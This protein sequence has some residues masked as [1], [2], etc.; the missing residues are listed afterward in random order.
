[1]TRDE[2]AMKL[3]THYMSCG[4]LMPITWLERN[5][6]GSELEQAFRMALD[7]LREKDAPRVTRADH[8]RAMTDEEL[9]KAL[10]ERTMLECPHPHEFC[11]TRTCVGCFLEWLQQPAK[12]ATP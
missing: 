12:E 11:K 7:A 4:M 9:A 2:A 10:G 3:T 8:I 6:R 5:G 1:M